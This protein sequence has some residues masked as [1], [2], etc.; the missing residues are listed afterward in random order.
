MKHFPY[1]RIR[2]GAAGKISA[3][4]I[5]AA[6]QE[7]L[8][9]GNLT[10]GVRLPPV[11][12]LAHQLNVS[13]N[14]VAAAYAELTARG[15]ISPDSTRGYF[16]PANGAGAPKSTQ[17]RVPGPSLIRGPFERFMP[18]SNGGEPLVLG[19][20]FIDRDLLPFARIAEC[21]RSVLNQPGLHYMQDMHGYKPLR[22]AIAKHLAKRG[23]QADPDWVI[24]TNGSQ[25]ALDICSRA[26]KHRRVATENPAYAIG[27]LLFAMNGVETAGLRLDPFSGIDLADWRKRLVAS[28]P[29]A[30]Y[31]TTNFQNPT[32]Y[33]YSSSE[34]RGII[35]LSREFQAGILEDD[36]G[37]EMLPY[38]EFRTPMRA[39][40]GQKV[41][42]INSFTKKLLPSL[43]IGYLLAD[44]E[45]LP[46]LLAA[47]RASTLGNPAIVEAALFEFL[48]RGYYDQH[49]KTLQ[50]ELDR[51]YQH[52]L[53]V[54][55]E[56]MPGEV[57][58]TTPGG[59][60]SLWLEIPKTV[61]L[62]KL[63]AKMRRKGV[64]LD[65]RTRAWFIG[66]P[67]LHGTRIGFAFL[68]PDAM[69]KGLELL[70]A[71]LREQLK[72]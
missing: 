18:S 11:R 36:W 43:R 16:V 52:C 67:H 21:F 58:W 45:S 63:D 4:A 35:E 28:R 69:A 48:D 54:L 62:S 20:V 29:S 33:S 41:L 19:S 66:T 17:L 30:L 37:S 38:S 51:R 64:T 39:M 27:Q 53:R 1:I 23:I 12:A 40:G 25:Q 60:P 49:L 14:T 3:K 57:K 71:T 44:D 9:A 32:G 5:T 22:E 55:S 46:A 15:K 42:Y 70:A 6:I 13:K 68:K 61:D 34:L 26:L 10:A 2:V 50:E 8:R 72:Q 24:I 59:G 31:L 47:K 65:M 56:V 7:E